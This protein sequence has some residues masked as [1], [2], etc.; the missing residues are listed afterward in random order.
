MAIIKVNNAIGGCGISL[1]ILRMEPPMNFILASK[2]RYGSLLSGHTTQL[3]VKSVIGLCNY[4][5]INMAELYKYNFLNKNSPK[6]EFAI[7]V[8]KYW[9]FTTLR[10]VLTQKC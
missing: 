6:L 2:P 1:Y 9:S 8:P 3:S 4:E 5:V 7:I 10:G